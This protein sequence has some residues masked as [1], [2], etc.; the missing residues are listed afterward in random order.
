MAT[1]LRGKKKGKEVFL[2][3]YANDWATDLDNKV[4]N[5]TSLLFTDKEIQEMKAA[6]CVG[7]MFDEFEIRNNRFY[8]KKLK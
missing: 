1:V 8:R 7:H 6:K 3:Q 4:Y 2:H 5:I